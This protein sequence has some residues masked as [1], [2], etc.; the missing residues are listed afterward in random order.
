MRMALPSACPSER[1]LGS[2][3]LK[4]AFGIAAIQQFHG[5][6]ISGLAAYLLSEQPRLRA[7]GILFCAR[8]TCETGNKGLAQ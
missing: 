3:L 6:E 2:G 4:M 8:P 7:S 1:E 5:F